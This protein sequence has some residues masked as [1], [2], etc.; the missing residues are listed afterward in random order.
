M[1]L[2]LAVSRSRPEVAADATA[3]ARAAF[4]VLGTAQQEIEQHY[5]K[6]GWVERR[7]MQYKQV[8]RRDPPK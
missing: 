5:P 1:R 8:E 3:R 7:N 2:M 4:A 6:D